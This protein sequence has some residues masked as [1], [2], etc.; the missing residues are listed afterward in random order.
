M[1][2]NVPGNWLNLW[3]QFLHHC[4]INNLYVLYAET[5]ACHK[6]IPAKSRF[7]NAFDVRFDSFDFYL[8]VLS[9]KW[10]LSGNIS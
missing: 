2:E 10:R 6:L 1:N 7:T 4:I 5:K 9:A 3:K 8:F